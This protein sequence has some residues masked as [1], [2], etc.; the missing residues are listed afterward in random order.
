MAYVELGDATQPAATQYAYVVEYTD[1]RGRR[2]RKRRPTLSGAL[3][4]QRG[5]G[6]GAESEVKMVVRKR[7]KHE[8]Q[9]DNS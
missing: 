6:Y 4:C 8:A 1:A 3:S 7:R 5:L 2:R 9:S